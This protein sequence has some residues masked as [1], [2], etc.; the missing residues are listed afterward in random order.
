MIKDDVRPIRIL[1][2]EDNRGDIFLT[3]RAFEKAKVANQIQVA[4][5][6]EMALNILRS[7]KNR[8]PSDE[9]IDIVLLDI[10][11][12][13]LDGKQVLAAMKQ[14]PDLRRIPVIIMS[15]SMEEQDIRQSYDLQAAGYVVKPLNFNKFVDVVSAIEK[16]WF[17]IVAL[18]SRVA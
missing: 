17:S 18:P 16:F 6:G 4:T 3:K 15:S 13:K 7:T 2:V 14:D 8:P 9:I 11:L 1:L 5:D 12:P 10:N